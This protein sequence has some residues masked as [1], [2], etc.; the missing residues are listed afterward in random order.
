MNPRRSLAERNRPETLDPLRN[1][2]S[3]SRAIRQKGRLVAFYA[4]VQIEGER[5][6]TNLSGIE[7]ENESS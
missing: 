7:R 2:A 5:D 4:F 3:P 1:S 6:T